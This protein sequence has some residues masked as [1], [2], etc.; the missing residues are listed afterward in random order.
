[1]RWAVEA[2]LPFLDYR[3][4]SFL[5]SLPPEQKIRGGFTKHVMREALKGIVPESIRMRT[6]KVGFSTP[7]ASWYRMGMLDFMRSV[8]NDAITRKRGLYD[9][10]RL[11]TLI[12]ANA[13]GKVEAGRVLW[14][15]LNLEL[16]FRR[17]ID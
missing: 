2:R 14:R 13:S 7:E 15:A 16:W 4:V 12:E 1:M 8:L 17:F 11:S 9:V 5:F 10:E 3:L 6:D